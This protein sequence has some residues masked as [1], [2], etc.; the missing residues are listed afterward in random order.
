MKIMLLSFRADVYK[1]VLTGQKIYE[2]RKVF[3][4][5]R[6]KAYLYVSSP[7]KAVT[8][9]MELG[10]KVSLEKWKEQYSYD[11]AA[12]ERIDE[13]LK[14]H[15]YAMEILS[16]QKT[17]MLSLEKIRND[18]QKF[19]VPQMYYYID[20]S[21]LLTYLEANLYPEGDIIEHHFDSISSNDI[22]RN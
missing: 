4:D 15:K 3:P 14:K 17:N 6:I 20:N 16:Y 2:H 22:C 11:N 9:I 8:G 19:T 7:I 5:G 13:Y 21:Q 1:K 18:L 12:V 10:N